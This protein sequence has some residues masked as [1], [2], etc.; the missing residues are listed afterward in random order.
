MGFCELSGGLGNGCDSC[1]T[2]PST[3]PNNGGLSN[4]TN[5]LNQVNQVQQV[6]NNQNVSADTNALLATF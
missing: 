4:Q 2:I 6:N 3:Y 1:A 5:Q